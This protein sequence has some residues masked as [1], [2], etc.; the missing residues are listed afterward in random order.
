LTRIG[1]LNIPSVTAIQ[2]LFL[3]CLS[4]ESIGGIVGKPTT[5]HS[6]F[7]GCT[8]L[9]SIGG[10]L[11]LSNIPSSGNTYSMFA[12]CYALEQVGFVAG[13]IHIGI[14]FRPCGKLNDASRQSIKNG[15]ADLTGQTAQTIQFHSDVLA[16]YTE[17]E[18]AE[19]MSKNWAVE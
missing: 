15:L 18:I 3:N 16:K 6:A 7:S 10:E 8:K 1:V 2:Y 17:D 11:D 13:S 4:L 5:V 19:M 14:D 12:A 9:A